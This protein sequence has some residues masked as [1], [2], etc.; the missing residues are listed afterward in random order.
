[1]SGSGPARRVG[2][3]ATY[4]I[5]LRDGM[6]LA[7]A[8]QLVPY[9]KALGVSHVYTS[10][11]AT[12][13]PGSMHGYDVADPG[14]VDE[15]IGGD[16]GHRQLSD[17]LRTSDLGRMIDIVPNHV[18]AHESNPWWR[19]VLHS[20]AESEYAE[21]FDVDWEA[22]AGR[23]VTDPTR[24]NYRRFFDISGLVGLRVEEPDVFDRSHSLVLGWLAAGDADALRVD[25]PD[26]LRHPREYFDRLRAA[27]GGAWTVVEK[28]LAGYE[29]LPADW[30]V[31]GTTGYEFA[32]KV[33][34]LNVDASNESR[35]TELYGELTRADTDWEAVSRQ[36][37]LDVLAGSLAGDLDR[38]AD[39]K[40]AEEERPIEEV[41][42]E[43]T[44]RLSTSPVYRDYPPRDALDSALRA[45]QL[46]AAVTAKGVEDTAFYRYTRFCALNEVGGE[47][48]RFGT[49]LEEFH[50][51]NHRALDRPLS[52][53]ATATHDTKWGE[54]VR[55]RMCVLSE[56]PDEW[57][58]VARRWMRDERLSKLEPTLAYALLQALVG[59]WPLPVER[60]L[61]YL[62]KAAREAKTATSWADPDEGYEE[63]IDAAVRDLL[64][65]TAFQADLATFARPVAARGRVNSL[66]T[67]LLKLTSPGVPDLYQGTELWDDALVDPDNR[68]PV[69]FA[70]RERALAQLAGAGLEAALSGVAEGLPKLWLTMKALAVRDERRDSFAGGSGY[71]QLECTG[72]WSD[73]VVAF[74]RSNEVVSIVPRLAGGP[75]GDWSATVAVVP[76]GEWKNA[77][78]GEE[79][80]GGKVPVADLWSRFPVALL[81]RLA[82]S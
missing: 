22:G 40:A 56:S 66:A 73:R 25:H 46:C 82:G 80:T 4:R 11:A 33:T 52:L 79:V 63:R 34:G 61:R 68:R 24:P 48:G 81:V 14:T 37:R 67:T 32:R 1:M 2:P 71:E 75:D 59:A 39:R 21:F 13:V 57:G 10:P 53:L 27:S 74:V 8:A 65:D 3:R 45:A 77:V 7:R 36:A 42:A 6:T 43:L 62:G 58:F 23:V 9:L 55:A 5:Q 64:G 17:A 47:P 18:A 76:A 38:L 26:G 49:G 69:D 72:R 12:A 15:A 29:E 19:D 51:A 78:T 54:D 35:L 50:A 44:E 16:E 41:K 20:G 31:D 60:A 70:G 28:I 30:D